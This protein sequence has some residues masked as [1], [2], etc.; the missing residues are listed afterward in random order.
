[1]DT[2][3]G[4][5]LIYICDTCHKIWNKNESE[6][7]INEYTDLEDSAID[8]IFNLDKQINNEKKPID[9]VVTRKESLNKSSI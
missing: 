1:M 8:E 2:K 3:T 5:D 7:N 6:Q 4:T 9:M